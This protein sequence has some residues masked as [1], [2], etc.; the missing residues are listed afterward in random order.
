MQMGPALLPTPLSPAR[1]LPKKDLAPGVS[2]YL[3]QAQSQVSAPALAPASGSFQFRIW[4]ED[5]LLHLSVPR[6]VIPC[7]SGSSSGSTF[8]EA[9]AF[10][11]LPDRSVRPIL[12]V[13]RVP[14]I[15]LPC[16]WSK[17]SARRS[18]G[19]RGQPPKCQSGL[20]NPSD[21]KSLDRQS[22][23]VS[24][25]SDDLRLRFKSESG[26]QVIHCKAIQRWTEVDNSTVRRRTYLSR[27]ASSLRRSALSLMKPSASCWS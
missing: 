23:K 3:G 24:R 22:E 1:G 16:F 20:K 18:T 8:A 19:P 11:S 12:T 7:W 21:F 10:P 26:K 14:I 2:P 25:L 17:P 27:W 6:P 4:S 13:L 15:E 9:P 5:F